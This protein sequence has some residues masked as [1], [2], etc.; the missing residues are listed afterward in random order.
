LDGL[1]NTQCCNN[2]TFSSF[3]NVI[4]VTTE[5]PVSSIYQLLCSNHCAWCVYVTLDVVRDMH[6]HLTLGL[7]FGIARGLAAFSTRSLD[8]VSEVKH[9]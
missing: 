5:L 2:I 7:N 9:G 4:L 8:M 1:P 6:T 3:S